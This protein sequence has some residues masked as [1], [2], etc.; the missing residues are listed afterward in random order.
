MKVKDRL[1]LQFTFMF[2]VLLFTVLTGIYLFVE[3]NR[4]K[5]F[6]NKLDDRAITVAQFY[7][8]EDNLSKVPPIL[9]RRD[10]KNL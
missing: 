6:F 2:A 9:I 4:V 1:S 10:D 5:G 8:A 3:H 7:L